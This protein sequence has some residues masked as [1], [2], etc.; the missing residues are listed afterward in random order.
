MIRQ[1]IANAAMATGCPIS[2]IGNTIKKA[3]RCCGKNDD[4]ERFSQIHERFM[5]AVMKGDAVNKGDILYILELL[6][7]EELN[8]V[9]ILGFRFRVYNSLIQSIMNSLHFG[10]SLIKGLYSTISKAIMLS[11]KISI[12]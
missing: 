1:S 2:F 7:T 4:T 11:F 12:T 5:E 6:T 10:S 9:Q 3:V 8:N